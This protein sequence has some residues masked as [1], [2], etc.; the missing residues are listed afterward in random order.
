[1]VTFLHRAIIGDVRVVW[2]AIS[3]I[4][5]NLVFSSIL[6]EGIKHRVPVSKYMVK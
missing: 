1:M 2:S 5:C 6:A 4:Y 3:F